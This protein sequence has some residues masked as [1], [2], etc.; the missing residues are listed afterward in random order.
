M[1]G[2]TFTLHGPVT[3]TINEVLFYSD[4]TNPQ[5]QAGFN[6]NSAH[7]GDTPSASRQNA[8]KYRIWGT[9]MMFG[10]RVNIWYH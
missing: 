4:F 1:V 9:S 5:I 10:A 6:P 3:G 7:P 8:G 2:E